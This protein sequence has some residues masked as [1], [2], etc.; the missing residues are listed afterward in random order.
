MNVPKPKLT[1]DDDQ[2]R[3]QFLPTVFDSTLTPEIK[4]RQ[5]ANDGQHPVVVWKCEEDAAERLDQAKRR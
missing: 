5:Y 2:N 1:N 3:A 4:R